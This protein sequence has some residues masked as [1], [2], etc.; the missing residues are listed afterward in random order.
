M[1]KR[2]NGT[3]DRFVNEIDTWS[4]GGGGSGTGL[5][6][7]ELRAAAVTVNFDGLPTSR[8][9]QSAVTTVAIPLV[10]VSLPNRK[11]ISIKALAANGDTIYV[12]DLPG[13]ISSDGYE[14]SPGDSIEVVLGP[15]VTP[16]IIAASGTQRYCCWE[17]A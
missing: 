3:P 11:E 10:A 2:V 9:T 5:T 16:S 17:V 13:D 14:L 8:I 12:L 6:D 1:T 7:A 15:L 4:N